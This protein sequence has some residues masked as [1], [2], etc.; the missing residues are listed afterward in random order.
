M[1]VLFT[2]LCRLPIFDGFLAQR[3]GS[4]AVETSCFYFHSAFGD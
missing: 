2:R 4:K 3:D 1:I